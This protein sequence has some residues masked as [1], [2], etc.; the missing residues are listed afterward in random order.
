MPFFTSRSNKKELSYRL[1]RKGSKRYV[2]EKLSG[3]FNEYSRTGDSVKVKQKLGGQITAVKSRMVNLDGHEKRF[4][5]N[6]LKDMEKAKK[7]FK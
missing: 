3:I 7:F 4:W 2:A 5:F 1:N 6:A